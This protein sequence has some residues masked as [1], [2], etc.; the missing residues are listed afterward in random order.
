MPDLVDKVGFCF[1]YILLFYHSLVLAF[2][3][4]VPRFPRLVTGAV[5][6]GCGCLQ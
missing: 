6:A 4:F 1:V 2:C 3:P 5:F